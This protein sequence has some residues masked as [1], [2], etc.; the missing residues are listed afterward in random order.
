MIAQIKK[1]S[2]T[3]AL[4]VNIY[5]FEN[6]KIEKGKGYI[7][8]D[9]TQRIDESVFECFAE[10][11]E[12]NGNIK[13]FFGYE[14]SL[15]LNR[16]E[17]YSD[18]QFLHLAEQYLDKMGWDNS[19][20]MIY[21]HTDKKHEHIH[22]LLCS[23]D[24]DGSRLDDKKDRWRSQKASRQLENELGLKET[25]SEK[26]VKKE[27]LKAVN[28]RRYYVQRAVLKALKS[29]ASKK[30]VERML[31]PRELEKI[32][33]GGMTNEEIETMLGAEREEKLRSVLAQNGHFDRLF[34]EELEKRLDHFLKASRTPED[35]FRKVQ[36]YGIYIR[37]VATPDGTGQ[38]VYGME[39]DSFYVKDS[40]LSARFRYPS[41]QGAE[42][43]N[44]EPA[45]APEEAERRQQIKQAAF[46]ALSKSRGLGEYADNLRGAGVELVTYQNSK[47]V[48]GIA[49]KLSSDTE[50]TKPLNGSDI[51]KRLTF[52]GVNRH[53]MSQVTQAGDVSYEDT[54]KASEEPVKEHIPYMPPL[55]GGGRKQEEEENIK[56]KKK[57]KDRG[58]G[59][60]M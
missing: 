7:L 36:N 9:N 15:N 28:S 29:Y 48:Y 16:D 19:P 2:S 60:S 42:L 40:A 17:H 14:I 22:I 47:G 34:K 24:F 6:V 4:S 3:H 46:A 37:K 26:T 23:V 53:F 45:K 25:K 30:A 11:I 52:G 50:D 38:F 31:E 5:Y 35:Y 41:L 32:R 57:K 21:R 1:I 18:D 39:K 20:H 10:T 59:L 43:R 49:Y 58:A 44:T 12:Q 13:S 51:S 56:K 55:P 54:V 33:L 27:S 8:A